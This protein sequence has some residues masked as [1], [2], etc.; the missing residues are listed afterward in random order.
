MIKYEFCRNKQFALFNKMLNVFFIVIH[1]TSLCVSYRLLYVAENALFCNVTQ[2]TVAIPYRH[3]ETIYLSEL[4]GARNPRRNVRKES[5]LRAA[6]CP[7]RAQISCTSR[8]KPEISCFASWFLV[9][10]EFCKYRVSLEN[11]DIYRLVRGHRCTREGHS[12]Y[13]THSY[14][15]E[16]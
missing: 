14:S 7:R 6:V 4:Q 1:P 15:S 11:I 8:R 10:S 5:P 16:R 2:R 13:H 12:L 9:A 3:F